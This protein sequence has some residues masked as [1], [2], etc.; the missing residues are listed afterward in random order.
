MTGRFALLLLAAVLPLSACADSRPAAAAKFVKVTLAGEPFRL[1]I[2]AQGEKKRTGLMY[3]ERIAP[4][5]GMI[6]VYPH[7]AAHGFWMKNVRVDLDLL[8]L[9][10]VGTVLRVYRMPAEAPQGPAESDMAYYRR[11]AA[12]RCPPMQY[13]VELPMGTATRL[14]L[15]AGTTLRL[16]HRRLQD[17]L[18]SREP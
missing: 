2:A 1:E 9:D 14:G 16:P 18:S 15:T 4:G 5:T 12:Y 17:A 8:C 3:R 11:L 6:F 10:S 13:A 7:M